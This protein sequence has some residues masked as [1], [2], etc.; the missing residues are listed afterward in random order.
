MYKPSCFSTLIAAFVDR[1]TFT[2]LAFALLA[3]SAFATTAAAQ[4]GRA[5]Y[6]QIKAL[7][8][9]GG[10]ANVNNLV[11]K[12]DRVEMTFTGSVYF[13]A[14][15]EGKITGAVFVGQG[16]F[17]AAVPSDEFEKANVKR[18]LGVDDVVESDFKT[19]VLR[20]SDDTADIIGA[21]RT[22]GAAS[23]EAQSAASEIDART[24]KETGANLSSRIA[25]SLLNK[26][27]PGFF[28]GHFDGGK[29]G[30]F[31]YVLDH[32]TR[33]P[34]DNFGI[35]AG[36]KGL[37]FKYDTSMMGNEVWTA[38]HSL[39][40]YERGSAPYS[41]ANDV[42][43]VNK[44]EMDID[45][46][47]PKKRLGLKARVNMQ[48]RF[49]N[50][51][52]VP[53]KVGESLGEYDDQRLKKQMR[54][55]SAK[56]KGAD[57]GFI[58]ED[59]EAGFTIFLPGEAAQGQLF[60]INL[61]MEGDFLQQPEG[62]GENNSYP[63]SN[64]S[65][66]PRHGYLDRSTFD[67]TYRHKKN[68]KVASVGVRKSEGPSESD[69]DVFVTK[70]EVGHPVALITF[71]VGQFRRHA[72][73]IKWDKGGTP[74]PL[75]FNSVE[76]VAI[77]E[78]FILA[79]LNNSVRYFHALFGDYPYG[80]YSAT[81]HP[82]GFG[83]GFPSMLMIPPTDRAS[84][85]TYAFVAHETAHQWWG[86][87]VAWRSYR[88]QWLSEGFAEYSGVLY[89]NLRKDYG[90]GKSLVDEMRQS[91]KEPPMT[92]TGPGKGKLVDVGPLILG[93]RL[94]SRKTLQGYQTLVYNKGALTLRMI[95]F[96]FTDPV[97]GNGQPFFD[98]MKDFVERYRNK[99][100]STNDFRIVANE[101]FAK[102]PIAAKY[103]VKNLDWFFRQWVYQ[104]E[105]PSYELEYQ[106][107]DQPD[108]S[109][110][111]SGNVLQTGAPA[112]WFMPL[113]L[114]ISFGGDKVAQGTVAAYGPKAPFKLKLPSKP[115][116]VELDPRRWVLSEK[117]STK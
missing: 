46:S 64:E 86:N 7:S 84:K 20:F 60:D 31:S 74:I 58:Q 39:A 99:T 71:A 42:V 21:A 112:D 90:A 108:G 81:V 29:R 28:F 63:R 105:L 70:Y 115:Q 62:L 106:F 25:I 32:Q 24:L 101:H 83:Q 87:V 10:K 13:S 69:K 107:E 6:A 109:V 93:H 111:L 23:P 16:V 40:D 30:R 26:E 65:W 76:G 80:T 17:R 77:K 92:L 18:L 91:L 110:M 89:T 5:I 61:E 78:D 2:G 53:F 114:I 79:E 88:D 100:A 95:H 56:A 14:P 85:Y 15:V 38:F 12:R 36:E 51:R 19:A 11:L 1:F 50:V 49:A 52:A 113:P 44:Y 117:T 66:Y 33:I 22:E 27:T 55:K 37:I 97:S 102:T 48:P 9:T 45:L 41:D 75:E 47:D 54:L 116:K 8:L 82:Y 98:M 43:D 3:V 94:S 59:W 67:L 34:T 73:T 4:D 96:L 57:L 104:A 35:N 68:L 72:D 103:G